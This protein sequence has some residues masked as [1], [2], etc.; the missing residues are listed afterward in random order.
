M[1]GD[2]AASPGCGFAS[3][4]G[5][6]G[7]TEALAPVNHLLR[8]GDVVVGNLEVLLSRGGVRDDQYATRDMRGWPRFATDLRH[9]GFTHLNLANNHALQHGPNV[10]A[11]TRALVEAAGI[12]CV[13]I[14]GTAPWTCEPVRAT[15]SDGAMVG[16]LGY[17]LRPRQYYRELVPPF[18]EGDARAILADVRRLKPDCTLL[19]VSVHWGED[20]VDRPSEAEVEF[21]RALVD[22]GASVVLGHH[23]HV[24]RPLER[25]G[26]GVIAYSLGNFVGDQT[27]HPDLTRAGILGCTTAGDRLATCTFQRT[28]LQRDFSVLLDGSP[29]PVSTAAP[30]RLSN[31]AYQR[32]AESRHRRFRRAKYVHAIRNLWRGDLRLMGQLAARTVVNRLQRLR[33][34]PR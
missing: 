10:F 25:Y 22:T 20:Y 11:E 30:G 29:A 3:R 1:L 18:A 12:T 14:R 26:P 16:L 5:A 31:E 32:E 15:L 23:P 7:M 28:R 17:C 27:W 21:A 8:S 9:A 34:R 2:S 24:L 4:Y 13:G 19:V 6:S 33:G